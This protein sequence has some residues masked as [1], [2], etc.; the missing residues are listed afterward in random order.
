MTTSVFMAMGNVTLGIPFDRIRGTPIRPYVTGGVGLIR[1]RIDDPVYRYSFVNNDAGVNAGGGVT[2]FLSGRVGVRA[3]LRYIRSLENDSL[4]NRFGLI[5]V[6]RLQY[7][8]TS[9][10]LVLR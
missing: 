9:F 7:W 4:P 2:G 3:D 6:T 5:D 1:T 8:Q 10:A